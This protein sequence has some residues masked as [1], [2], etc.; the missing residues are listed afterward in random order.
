MK[1][2][3]AR[4]QHEVLEQIAWSNVLLGFDLDGTL[5]PIVADPERAA[6]RVAT[7]RRL[8]ELV[9][10]YPCVVISGR[11][12]ADA[13]Q[14]LAGVGVR[15]VIGNHGLE[16]WRATEEMR[17][18][19]EHWRAL[20]EEGLR[21]HPGITIEDKIYSIALHHRRSRNKR[22]ARAAIEAVL[23]HIGEARVIGGKQ[24]VNVLPLGAPHK[25]VALERERD[26][27]GCDTAFYI[28]DDETDE[29]VFELDRPGRLYTV[30]VGRS[31]DSEASYFLKSQ[32]DVDR[33]LERLIAL[34]RVQSTSLRRRAR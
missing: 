1:D 6:M 11:G 22:A 5:A 33:L 31:R 24:V 14:R 29:D 2:I 18:T 16:P 15:T 34:R 30:R 8:S 25:G 19:V 4:A 20:F 17:R 26:F 23:A 10:L 7:R 13:A 12:V 28:G 9:G 3:L 27:A 32:H 21:G